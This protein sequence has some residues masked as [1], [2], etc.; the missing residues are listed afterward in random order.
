MQTDAA[1]AAG[2]RG[3]GFW[4]QIPLTDKTQGLAEREHA[5]RLACIKARLLESFLASSRSVR[6]IGVQFGYEAPK[7]LG[8]LQGNNPFASRW[9]SVLLASGEVVT[10]ASQARSLHAYLMQSD[11]G[12]LIL[13]VWLEPGAQFVPDARVAKD[14]H[15]LLP[16]GIT[17][18]FEVTTT[19]IHSRIK[20]TPVAGGTE[21]H[22]DELSLFSAIIATHSRE[23]LDQIRERSRLFRGEG[24]RSWLALGESKLKRTREVHTQL[25]NVGA[26]P[27]DSANTRFASAEA[28]LIRAKTS[29]EKQNFDAVRSDCEKALQYLRLVQRQH[30]EQAVQALPSPVAAPDTFCFQTLPTHWELMADI[31]RRPQRTGNLLESGS[32][33]DPRVFQTVGWTNT[34]APSAS[35]RAARI[36]LDPV[37]VVGRSALVLEIP[38]ATAEE[39]ETGAQSSPGQLVSPPLEVEANDVVLITGQIRIPQRLDAPEEGFLL[40]DTL[41]DAGAALRWKEATSGWQPFRIIR[42]VKDAQSFQLHLELHGRGRVEIDDLQV[43]ALVEASQ[44]K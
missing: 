21:A 40:Y 36:A 22:L 9:D 37:G 17:A 6:E 41:S 24:A 35:G 1:L 12:F 30:W 33:E 42:R 26:P 10:P 25:L 20:L 32:F 31:G 43:M 38:Y 5:I 39:Q 28:L 13:P 16:P 3:L 44:T 15:L 19:G 2:Y 7:Q 11:V 34:S 14:V 18:A 8:L 29:F 4:K 23:T 27:V